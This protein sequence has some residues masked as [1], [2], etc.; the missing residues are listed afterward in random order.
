V[1]GPYPSGEIVYGYHSWEERGI[2]DVTVKAFD[3]FVESNWSEPHS[4]TIFE[5]ELKVKEI[6]G[7][8]FKINFV[9]ENVGDG[10]ARNVTWSIN[11]TKVLIGGY[12]GGV[13]PSIKPNEEV[14]ITSNTIIGLGRTPIL[15][16]IG[17]IIMD[18]EGVVI[19]FI[20]LFSKINWQ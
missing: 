11:L 16:N 1:I 13:I 17:D 14:T 19:L 2:Y 20:I 18:N 6:S 12:S 9:V 5:P 4:I 8:L 3:G 7:G 15:V 10:E